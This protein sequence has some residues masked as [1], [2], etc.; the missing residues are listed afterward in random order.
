MI[1][2]S[3]NRI[4]STA[5]GKFYQFRRSVIHERF[6]SF[7]FQRAAHCV[8]TFSGIIA[9]EENDKFVASQ[10]GAY[11]ARSRRIF[12]NGPNPLQILVSHR[13]AVHVVNPLQT[14]GVHHN[15]HAPAQ[16]LRPFKQLVHLVVKAPSVVETGQTVMTALLSQL[17]ELLPPLGQIRHIVGCALLVRLFFNFQINFIAVSVIFI[18]LLV[19]VHR[20]LHGLFQPFF[21]LRHRQ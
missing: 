10:T 12:D 20:A 5:D 18:N 15:N 13:V 9:V 16:I 17:V 4:N 6:A 8:D 14:V 3:I 21:R 1:V 19:L 11:R 2:L 7:L